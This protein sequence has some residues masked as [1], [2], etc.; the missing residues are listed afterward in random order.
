MVGV[1]V[2]V[3]PGIREKCRI[4]G[5]FTHP[6]APQANLP[7]IRIFGRFDNFRE[8]LLTDLKQSNSAL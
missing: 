1:W 2:W 6:V 7:K 5:V 8:T 4:S 3:L